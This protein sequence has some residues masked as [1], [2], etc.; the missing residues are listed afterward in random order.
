MWLNASGMEQSEQ[1][2]GEV[3][4]VVGQT[5]KVVLAQTVVVALAA[6]AL[7]F[8]RPA[9]DAALRGPMGLILAVFV[10]SYPLRI[11]PAVLQG[12]QDLKFLGQLRLALW[13]MSTVLVI[14]ML[15]MGARFYAL[16]CGWCL[17]QMGHDLVAF[18]RLRRLRPDLL[19]AEDLAP[20]RSHALALVRA[21]ILGQ[22]QPGRHAVVGR[23]RSVDRGPL[24]QRRH[25]GG[26]LFHQQVDRGPP[27][28]APDSCQRRASRTQPH[29]NQR[30]ARANPAGHHFA[31]ASH[32]A[33]GRRRRLCIILA[34][35]QQFV[36][37]W[38]GA[39]FFGGMQLTVILLSDLSPAAGRLYAGRHAVCVRA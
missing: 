28:P 6:L 13:G 33:A 20:G 3:A 22:C 7:F 17:Q 18:F 5:L 38:L 19:S 34:V 21:R 36:T 10:I 37:L 31:H 2:S 4:R 27:E 26:L 16:A 23:Q 29:E 12:L 9:H 35:N 39:H 30:I 32:A 25:R 14:V 24:H 1:A 8:L 11:F 15:L